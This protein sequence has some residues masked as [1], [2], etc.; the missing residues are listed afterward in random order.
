[1]DR[2]AWHAA[3]H[4]VS[5]S[6]TQLSDWTELNMEKSI[7]TQTTC[8]ACGDPTEVKDVHPFN[9][10]LA[11]SN[12]LISTDYMWNLRH[13]SSMSR[14]KREWKVENVLSWLS[15][16]QCLFSR[17]YLLSHSSFIHSKIILSSF[18]HVAG[19]QE[20]ERQQQKVT[21]NRSLTSRKMVCTEQEVKPLSRVRLSA[22]P[23]L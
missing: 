11:G 2:E 15:I 20:P 16:Y 19:T 1:M 22:T 12:W 13:A 18:Y 21:V 23:G 6:Q 14:L 8:C 5:K 9:P 7:S 10:G 4:G 3:V 17:T